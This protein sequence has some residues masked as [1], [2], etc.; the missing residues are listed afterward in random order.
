MSLRK[1]TL[2]TLG[3]TIIG[4]IV[5]L[6]VVLSIITSQNYKALEA[7][8]AR[9]D[10]N[11]AGNTLQRDIDALR[12]T[13]QSW[14]AWDNSR[15]FMMG[16]R[17]AYPIENNL[18]EQIT[19]TLRLNMMLFFDL[20]GNMVFGLA[21][22]MIN[23]EI[24]PVPESFQQ[25]LTYNDWLL[26][27]DDP[28]EGYTGVV[29]LPEGPLLVAAQPISSSNYGSIVGTLI[30]TRY[31]D[32]VELEHLQRLTELGIAVFRWDSVNL[33]PHVQEARTALLK[34]EDMV[35]QPLSAQ[36][37]AGYVVQ[38][39]FSDQP[40]FLLQ[41]T[42]PRPIYQASQTALV[43]LLVALLVAG[44]V[45]SGATMAS[46]EWM[47]LRR[48]TRLI[49]DVVAISDS[50]NDRLH[51]TVADRDELG[52]LGDAINRMLESLQQA[53][54]REQEQSERA[55]R[56]IEIA[57]DMKSKFIANMSHELRTPLNSIINFTYMLRQ[58]LYGPITQQ[59][60]K[61]LERVYANG[62]HLL[63]MI[64]DILDLSKIEA[65]RLDLF[66][67]PLDM[68]ELVESTMSTA[69]GLTKGKPIELEQEIDP[70]LPTIE[71]DKT[72]IRQ[73][74]LN[75]LSNAAKFTDKGSITVQVWQEGE[76]EGQQIITSVTDTGI[77]I[78]SGKIETIFEEFRQVDEGSNRSYQG[79]G[80]G[81]AI[82]KRLVEMHGGRIWVE[83]TVGVG[84]TF[85]FNLPLVS[86]KPTEE[87]DEVVPAEVV[88]DVAL[89]V[90]IPIVVVE[91]D[92]SAVEIITAYLQP[93]GYTVH[94]VRDSRHAL[95]EIRRLRPA[96]IILDI[97]MPHKDGWNVLSD[98]KATPDLRDI[99][100]IC[101]TIVD[102]ARLG[103]SLGAS[104]YLVKP[105]EAEVLRK[106][107]RQF[108]GHAGYI[109]VIDDDPYVREM[110]PQYLGK[111]G[112]D[113][114][115]AA[116]GREGLEQIASHPPDLI[117]LDLMMP[118]L[119]GFGVL[120]QLEQDTTLRAIP[121]LVLTARD[122]N[123]DEQ[124]HLAER[125]QGLLTKTK[126]TPGDVLARVYAILQQH[127][128]GEAG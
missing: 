119:D 124:Q 71:A 97:L 80:L 1:K 108:V 16:E 30:A 54:Q 19:A 33:P 6:S 123:P 77:G 85:F 18:T 59:Q 120:E 4:L 36:Q 13:I 63:G 50:G 60:D 118:E 78:P 3:L 84:S 66:K 93:E 48:L 57:N 110:V 113:V 7:D 100:V 22:D 8:Q 21:A 64:N 92:P 117:I 106:T 35:I 95:E 87:P 23:Q 12:L 115:T 128:R 103:M 70:D 40:A 88:P 10:V 127:Q 68:G 79:T 14:A 99:P 38:R 53:H 81:L 74:L 122:L 65:G 121:V 25:Y 47:V 20:S 55:R 125:V 104:A 83:S 86:H 101:Y 89:P 72:R 31:I 98:L 51:L 15:E 28:K 107:V 56:Q 102:D 5:S 29:L 45:F 75:L 52:H 11:R 126:S 2:V 39:D 42:T 37:I 76:G 17:P 27:H 26:T 94:P 9:Q 111:N 109:L 41:V 32:A 24:Q 114:A 90:G 105:I 67:E 62:E 61:Y 112:Y 96:A 116:D 91:D 82:C 34:G 46:M 73:V 58:N 69:M 49:A 44:V 43:A